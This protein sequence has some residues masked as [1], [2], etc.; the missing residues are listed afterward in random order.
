MQPTG[1]PGERRTAHRHP[2]PAE[3][4]EQG[5]V[6]ALVAF[7][8]LAL[9]WMIA[10]VVVSRRDLAHPGWAIALIVLTLGVTIAQ[11]VAAQQ[12]DLT[13]VRHLVLYAELPVGVL[14]VAE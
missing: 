2:T 4:L 13:L 14:L 5:L 1:E 10:V 12:S 6:Q 9:A 7:R 8:W 11:T 3:P